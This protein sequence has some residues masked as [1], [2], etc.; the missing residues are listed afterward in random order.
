M[1]V[2]QTTHHQGDIRYGM[3]SRGIQCS[4]MSLMSVSWTLF[5]CESIWDSFDL[6][7]I[8]QKGDILFKSL[9]NYAYTGM[10]DIPQEIF[11]E[12]S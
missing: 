2:V 1:K 12:N 5:K 10:E 3:S 6:D 8:L 7:C 4:C 11:I 9:N